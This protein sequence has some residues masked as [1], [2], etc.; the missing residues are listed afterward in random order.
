MV[1]GEDEARIAAY[2]KE[3][4]AAAAKDMARPMNGSR[5]SSKG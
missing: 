1:E 5:R 4:V 2:A 3:L